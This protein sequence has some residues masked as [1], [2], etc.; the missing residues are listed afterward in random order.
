MQDETV[1]MEAGLQQI[2]NLEKEFAVAEYQLCTF[3][4]YSN[5]FLSSTL[6]NACPVKEQ[7]KIFASLYEKRDAVCNEIPEFWYKVVSTIKLR[8]IYTLV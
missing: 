4:F 5:A 3:T 2:E 6:T 8:T 1:Q 7:A